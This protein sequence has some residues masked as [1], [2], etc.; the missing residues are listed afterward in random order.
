MDAIIDE[1]STL[2]ALEIQPGVSYRLRGRALIHPAMSAGLAAGMGVFVAATVSAS[3]PGALEL[4]GVP[5][6]LGVVAAGL[7]LLIPPTYVV[8]GADG[9]LLRSLGRER[10]VG[11]REIDSAKS[12]DVWY[13]AALE[14]ITTSGERIRIWCGGGRRSAIAANLGQ[15]IEAFQQRLPELDTMALLPRGRSTTDWLRALRASGSGAAPLRRVAPAADVLWNAVESPTAPPA[16]RAGA[17]VA[18]TV[19]LTAEGRERLLVA[20]RATAA[21]GL[22]RVFEAAAADADEPALT[23]A[24][25]T[26]VRSRA[27]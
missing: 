3:F 13:V 10:F 16:A 26:F 4:A 21:P 12:S 18:L 7:M 5:V 25:G 8:V 2:R 14:L 27:T 24:L 11:Y 6:F 19:G 23:R 9:V 22:A 20:A 15:A 17:A 1:P